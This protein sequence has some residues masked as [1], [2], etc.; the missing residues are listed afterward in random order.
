MI[1]L[2]EQCELPIACVKL[3]FYDLAAG[4]VCLHGKSSSHLAENMQRLYVS[5]LNVEKKLRTIAK[6]IIVT[7][8]HF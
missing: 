1:R 5:R 6:S 2:T 8:Q 3:N 7:K 4:S